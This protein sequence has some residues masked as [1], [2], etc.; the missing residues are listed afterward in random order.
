[1]ASF[2][3][4]PRHNRSAIS[5]SHYAAA[6]L[7]TALL[8]AS[9]LSAQVAE[10]SLADVGI[11]LAD[12]AAIPARVLTCEAPVYRY[13]LDS[14]NRLLTLRLR[15]VRR[16]GKYYKSRG[17][18]V[19][20]D[21][22]AG[23]VLWRLPFTYDVHKLFRVGDALVFFDGQRSYLLDPRTGRRRWELKSDVVYANATAGVAIGYLRRPNRMNGDSAYNTLQGVDLATGRPLWRRAVDRTFG[24]HDV[25]AQGDTAIVIAAAGLHHVDLRTG[26]GWDYDAATGGKKVGS[27]LATNAAGV[28]LG[29]LTGTGFFGGSPDIVRGMHAN[30]AGDSASGHVFY[31]SRDHLARVDPRDGRLVWRRSLPPKS[32]A[33][34]RLWVTDSTVH[35][36]SFGYGYMG[37]RKLDIGEASLAAFAKTD[38]R[39]LYRELIPPASGSVTGSSLEPS[40]RHLWLS[41]AGQAL[42][43]DLATGRVE[44]LLIPDLGDDQTIVGFLGDHVFARPSVEDEE[45]VDTLR[46]VRDLRADEVLLT[47]SREVTLAADPTSGAT[48][49]VPYET[50][51][52][53]RGHPAGPLF[54]TDD[55]VTYVLDASGAVRARLRVGAGTPRAG[56][57][58]AADGDELTLVDLDR[59]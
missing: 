14:A 13:D 53:G 41:Q 42:R 7:T 39:T 6:C 35:L 54:C 29:V 46:R 12:R 37:R 18:V 34:G 22:A 27:M 1:M 59:L 40:G 32:T 5:P 30:V 47:T 56:Y 26:R 9:A 8:A 58:V 11:R 16:K 25:L 55:D 52:L 23:R 3:T 50:M 36:A 17:T 44:G 33:T 10:S 51:M 43:Y 20:Y 28:A 19:Q 49:A 21:L 57:Y 45:A 2:L 38:G 48:E 24:W 4:L 31:A 15:P